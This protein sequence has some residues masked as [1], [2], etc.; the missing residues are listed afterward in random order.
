M[1]LTQNNYYA[2]ETDY[3]Y[4]SFSLYKDFMK[5]E[6]AALAKLK[7]DWQPT[8][9]PTPLLVGNYVHSTFESEQAHEK[10]LNRSELGD[11]TN[12]ELM[13]TKPTK[14]DPD[15]HLRAEFKLADE[16]IKTLKDDDLFNFVYQ[17]GDGEKEVIVTGKMDGIQ[18][19]GKIDSLNLERGYFVDLKTVDD[20]H[21]KHWIADESRWGNFIE[22][23]GYV[24][25]MAIYKELIKQTFGVDCQPYMFA[26]S[27]QTPPDKMAFDFQGDAIFQME[28]AIQQI[29][30]NQ[31]NIIEVMTGEEKPKYC[32]KCE[33]CR[34]T[35]KLNGF[36]HATE[37]DFD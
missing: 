22:S 3:H 7:E 8:S 9:N 19:K 34:S 25:Q 36:I 11:K 35:K 6:A 17:P 2:H 24:M 27:K 4:L 28:E 16:M 18:W 13:M 23:R 29:K 12:R 20:I 14:K 37:I 15:G 33:Y 21:K 30:E 31:G 5:C 32:G 26:V 10:W 1:E